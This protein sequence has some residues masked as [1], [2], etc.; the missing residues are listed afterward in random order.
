MLEI[1]D[2]I[3]RIEGMSSGKIGQI[4]SGSLNLSET[5]KPHM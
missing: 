1:I 4:L 3:H 2:S 5:S